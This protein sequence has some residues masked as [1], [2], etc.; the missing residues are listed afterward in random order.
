MRIKL[1]GLFT[2][3]IALTLSGAALGG[4][5]ESVD[6]P[7]D[8][9]E[10]ALFAY[11]PVSG[12][13]ALQADVGYVYCPDAGGQPILAVHP[14][15]EGQAMSDLG[16][17]DRGDGSWSVGGKTVHP[18]RATAVYLTANTRSDPD[19][20]SLRV[21]PAE[22][23]TLVQAQWPDCQRFRRGYVCAGCY[24]CPQGCYHIRWADSCSV[25][26]FGTINFKRCHYTGNPWDW[27]YEY[28]HY[29]CT[30]VGYDCNDCSGTP[31][32]A[33]SWTGWSCWIYGC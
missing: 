2:L 26:F 19:D 17:I 18:Q 25:D 29:I 16:A 23:V 32:W 7:V 4:A 21:A 13:V 9:F 20:Q 11:D 8:D 28:T 27:C 10:D 30:A 3:T 5:P 31:L 22:Q 24:H 1:L 6:A 14:D 15:E 33:N 12:G